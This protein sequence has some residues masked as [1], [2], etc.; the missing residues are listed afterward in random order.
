MRWTWKD[1]YYLNN[2]DAE[3]LYKVLYISNMGIGTLGTRDYPANSSCRLSTDTSTVFVFSGGK[4]HINFTPTVGNTVNHKMQGAGINKTI[5]TG[6]MHVNYGS[7]YGTTFEAKDMTVGAVTQDSSG[8]MRTVSWTFTNCEI[9]GLFS[10]KDAGSL[11]YNKCLFRIP[12]YSGQRCS[13]TGVKGMNIPSGNLNLVDKC[14]VVVT[15]ALIDSYKKNYIGFNDCRFKI[16]KEADFSPLLPTDSDNNVI[17]NPTESDFRDEFVNRCTKENITASSVLD[18]DEELA[19]GRW[20][21]SKDSALD[22]VVLNDSMIHA[23]EKRRYITLGY[24][25]PRILN[26]RIST[27]MTL[28]N[29]ITPAGSND[30]ANIDTDSFTFSSDIDITNPCTAYVTSNIIY[31]GGKQQLN[32]INIVNNL[33]VEYGVFL[34]NTPSLSGPVTSIIPYEDGTARDYIVRSSNKLPASITYDGVTYTTNLTSKNN[35]F[36]GIPGKTMFSDIQGNAAVYEITDKTVAQTIQMR[37]VRKVPSSKITTGT[38]QENYWYYVQHNSDREDAIATDVVIYNGKR[39]PVGGSFLVK[40]VLNFSIPTGSNVHLR[41][42]WREDYDNPTQEITDASFWQ[43][44]QKP[45]WF[46]V[47]PEDPRCIMK[48][49]SSIAVEMQE[50][51][52]KYIASGHPDFYNEIKGSAGGLLPAFPIKGSYM[53]LRLKITTLNPIT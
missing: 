19:V 21:F 26:V 30:K 38:L 11:I 12:D 23:F 1:K 7:I 47:I 39:Y 6:I 13:Y 41:R 42:C 53:Q 35:L 25:E 49:N 46:D 31:L 10:K 16:G 14:D 34:D 17:S 3:K 44:E 37:I 8:N 40:G 33:P 2:L 43:N 24:Y 27:D 52:G 45:K 36:R 28:P 20:I 18:F 9:N 51:D 48:N 4:H 29:S 5:L 22:G 15:Q 32:K 50:R